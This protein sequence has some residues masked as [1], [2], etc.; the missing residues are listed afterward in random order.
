MTIALNS[1][2]RD[3]VEEVFFW[4]SLDGL[5]PGEEEGFALGA[6]RSWTLL[7]SGPHLMDFRARVA[8]HFDHQLIRAD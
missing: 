5:S 7:Q 3:S 8:A 4:A 2:Q 1:V 6:A